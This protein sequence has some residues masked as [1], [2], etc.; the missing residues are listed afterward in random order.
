MEEV[1]T[2]TRKDEIARTA[3][4]F[5]ETFVEGL[6]GDDHPRWW[7]FTMEPL[8]PKFEYKCNASLGSPSTSNCEA[9][10]YE[11]FESGPVVLDPTAGPLIKTS[12]NCAIGVK[13]TSKLTTTWEMLRTVAEHLLATCITDPLS[14]T[15]GGLATSQPVV[16]RKR[17]ADPNT[18]P[19][20]LIMAAYFQDHFNGAASDTCAWGVVLS[21][22]SS[23]KGDVRQCPAPTGPWRPPERKLEAN[24]TGIH[25]WHGGNITIIQN[26]TWTEITEGNLTTTMTDV[27]LTSDLADLPII[28]PLPSANPASIPSA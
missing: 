8:N 22:I 12:G 13:T 2:V 25:E 21:Q 23:H 20:S 5:T 28:S 10:L 11:F 3:T 24:G 15:R 26:G 6:Y 16:G 18:W 19:S 7:E 1:A 9:V 14:G 4:A 17:R 27:N